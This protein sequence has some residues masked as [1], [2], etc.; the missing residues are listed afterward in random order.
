M[1]VLPTLRR[2]LAN[3]QEGRP[4]DAVRTDEL[5]AADPAFRR[6][7]Q[8][9]AAT[10][11]WLQTLL[12]AV[13]AHL[14]A[15]LRLCTNVHDDTPPVTTLPGLLHQV[16][17]RRDHLRAELDRGGQPRTADQQRL[18]DDLAELQARLSPPLEPGNAAGIPSASG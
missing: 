8:A 6:R 7:M 16:A 10:D 17:Q 14:H 18:L 11:A 2:V 3:L 1:A 13:P 5:M 15:A 4:A 9:Q 12:P